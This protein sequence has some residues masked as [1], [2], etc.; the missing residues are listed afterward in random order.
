MILCHDRD[1]H[2]NVYNST[3]K[4]SLLVNISLQ[5]KLVGWSIDSSEWVQIN[6]YVLFYV[7]SL[8]FFTIAVHAILPHVAN[9]SFYL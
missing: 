1:Y 6:Y 3:F 7:F 9:T 8:V 4:R 5:G 2:Q